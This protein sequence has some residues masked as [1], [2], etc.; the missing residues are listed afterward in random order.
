M[1]KLQ[2]IHIVDIQVELFLLNKMHDQC[3]QYL[4]AYGREPGTEGVEE[5]ENWRMVRNILLRPRI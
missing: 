4:T 5:I 3:K 2:T 1:N